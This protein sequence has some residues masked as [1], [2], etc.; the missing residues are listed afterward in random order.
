MAGLARMN[1]GHLLFIMSLSFT[2]TSL[3][4][5]VS[6]LYDADCSKAI[7]LCDDLKYYLPV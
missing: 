7:P 6:L 4:H 5:K 2:K 3:H 1:I